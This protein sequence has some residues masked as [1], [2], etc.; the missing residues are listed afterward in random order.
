MLVE[1]SPSGAEQGRRLSLGFKEEKRDIIIV[2]G[3]AFRKGRRQR[4]GSNAYS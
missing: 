4:Q 3:Q 2:G 1:L